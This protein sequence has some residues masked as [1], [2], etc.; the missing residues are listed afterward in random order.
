MSELSEEDLQAVAGGKLGPCLINPGEKMS[1]YQICSLSNFSRNY[2]HFNQFLTLNVRLH[3]LALSFGA[4][5]R[6]V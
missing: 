6:A 4:I 2:F 3:L 1:L 5:A